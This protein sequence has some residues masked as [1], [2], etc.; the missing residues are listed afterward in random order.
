MNFPLTFLYLNKCKLQWNTEILHALAGVGSENNTMSQVCYFCYLN[1]DLSFNN[2]LGKSESRGQ[3][4]VT[5]DTH[6]LGS[7][8]F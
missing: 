8:G 2:V 7:I 5:P 1:S 3:N 6:I 4:L